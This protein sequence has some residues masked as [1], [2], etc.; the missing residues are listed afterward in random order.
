V[1]CS[2]RISIERE[3]AKRVNKGNEHTKEKMSVTRGRECG[4]IVLGE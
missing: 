2:N 1:V 3:F 4:I